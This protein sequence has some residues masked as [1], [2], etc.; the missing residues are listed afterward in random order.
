MLN[1]RYQ[2][3]LMVVFTL[4]FFTLVV[5]NSA[6]AEWP[7]FRFDLEPRYEN[8]Q[9]TYTVKFYKRTAGP[10][11]DV[12]I[13]IPLP[14]GTR[15]VEA[16]A[17][18]TTEA[19]FDGE[20][21][22][23]LTS[24][25][26]EPIRTASFVVEVTNPDRIEFT[27]QPWLAW[28]GD[29]P[30]DYLADEVTIDITKQYLD[31]DD[32]R[33]RLQLEAGATV[34]DG[35]ITYTIY[36]ER[37]SQRQMWDL[38]VKFPLPPGTTLLATEAPPT[39]TTDFDG[40]EVTFST[41]E[42]EY[43]PQLEP[44]IIT[45]STDQVDEPFVVTH[46][47]ATWKNE[48][49]A[50]SR[51]VDFQEDIR[52]GD[53]VVYLNGPQEVVADPIGDV[54]FPSYDLTSIAL[55]RET[56]GL[57]MTFYTAADME[58]LGSPIEYILYIDS[59]CTPTTGA[60]RAD[61]GAEYWVRY[62][63]TIGKAAV[64]TWNEVERSWKNP[65]LIEVEPP[66]GERMVTMRMGYD[67]FDGADAFCWLGRARNRTDLYTDSPD[68]E[69]V[70]LET[71]L[72]QYDLAATVPTATFANIAVPNPGWGI[73]PADVPTTVDT[74]VPVS[75]RLAV[76]LDN[77]QGSYDVHIFSL[78]DG[79]EMSRIPFARQPDFHPNGERL[80]VN[81]DGGETDAIFEYNL[82]DGSSRRVSDD[83]GDSHPVYD[84]WGN[85]VAYDN[86]D[87]V[88]GASGE[89]ESFIFVQCGL[90][91]PHQETEARCKE[92]TS[93]GKLIPAGHIGE[94]LGSHPVWL[95]DERIAYKGCNSWAGYALCGIY[96]VPSAST[97][98]F[99]DG[100]MPHQLTDNTTD[101]PS[102]TAGTWLTFS[103]NRDGNWE[104]Y[105]M[106]I[107]GQQLRNLSNSPTSADGLP[108]ISPDGNWAAFVS[109]RDGAW[110]VWVVPLTG[111]E[112]RKLFNLPAAIP[113][114]DGERSWLNE[115]LSWGE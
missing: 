73:I 48:G 113:W 6:S 88:I 12:L 77:G 87:S 95:D 24:T 104:A 3:I 57:R 20:A 42:V 62:K 55:Q 111:G 11:A 71:R 7:P 47:W 105:V 102:D 58:P 31:W 65:Q 53:I 26:H 115:R 39:F 34:T 10:L 70:G 33:S 78:P 103:S 98:G 86:D 94:L 18:P 27:T 96:V 30:G 32:P 29:I 108:T 107:N 61:L 38:V 80:L 50:V 28:K 93:L 17:Q 43:K 85:R 89:P 1:V 46:A 60:G 97:K 67:L 64:Y 99:S 92:I 49:R 106:D 75:G 59:D 66:P 100:L 68:N 112:P 109:D 5:S 82:A 35:V 8:G 4:V 16:T 84:P 23:F 63:H 83:A 15:F 45:V 114:G 9:I 14:E 40:Q 101:I 41:I 110:A 54:P 91:P 25:L 51:R 21:I 81:R 72:T 76:P 36:P 37:F 52:S 19:T 44:F 90:Q 79:Q 13:R 2:L 74:S 22:T 56:S 69:W